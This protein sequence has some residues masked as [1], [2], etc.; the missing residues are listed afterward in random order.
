VVF[1]D[2][3]KHVSEGSHKLVHSTALGKV[4]NRWLKFPGVIAF[5]NPGQNRTRL[6]QVNPPRPSP[7]AP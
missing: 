5:H 7:G 3:R 4:A 1:G 6:S 2:A